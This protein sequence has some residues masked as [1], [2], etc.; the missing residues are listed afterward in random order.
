MLID[1]PQCLLGLLGDRGK[2]DQLARCSG[3]AR[4]CIEKYSWVIDNGK[5]SPRRKI[6][7]ENF[8]QNLR[9]R[10][11]KC[12]FFFPCAMCPRVY[13]KKTFEDRLFNS[14]AVPNRRAV[15]K[16]LLHWHFI[17]ECQRAPAS[18]CGGGGFAFNELRFSSLFGESLEFWCVFFCLPGIKD[19]GFFSPSEIFWLLLGSELVW[20]GQLGLLGGRFPTFPEEQLSQTTWRLEEV[21]RW[22]VISWSY[23]CWQVGGTEHDQHI[24]SW[25]FRI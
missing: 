17:T 3:F 19:G 8:H 6:G 11:A 22:L 12:F 23:H 18:W 4:W 7:K 5:S 14:R 15:A 1:N 20:C 21:S 9:N 24:C 25:G 13:L 10:N 2:V 16:T